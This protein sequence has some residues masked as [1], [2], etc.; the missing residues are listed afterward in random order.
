MIARRI[1]G[2]NG[3]SVV[4]EKHE[5][6]PLLTHES[7]DLRLY[8]WYG[9][10][11]GV[12]VV[13]YL[14]LDRG[15]AHFH[16]PKTPAFIGE[17]TLL[18][19]VLAIAFGTQWLRRA[20]QGD[21]L[22]ATLI[23]YMVWCFF[24]TVPNMHLFGIQVTVRDAA[25]WYYAGFAIALV[26]ACTAVPDLLPKLIRGFR[27]VLPV[28]TVWLPIA[29]LLERSGVQG[30]RFRYSSV[31]LLSHKPGNICCAAVICLAFLL[32]VPQNGNGN[33][34]GNGI[35]KPPRVRLLRQR[36]YR[37]GVWVTL[38]VINV[39]TMLLGATQTRG[40]AVAELLA[41]FVIFLLM[42]R[43][44]RS[45]AIVA[46]V[47]GL[48]LVVGLGL[49]TGASY[50]TQKRTISV[51]QLFENAS[52]LGGG[53][54]AQL[55]GS[56]SF[57]FDLWATILSKQESTSHLLDGFGFGVNL[58]RTGGL[59]PRP[60]QPATLQLRS[61]HN[62]WLDVFART[63]IIGALLYLIVWIGWFRRMGMA[64]RRARDGEIRGVIGVC[65]AGVIALL[66][67]SFFDPTLEGAQVAAVLFTLFAIGIVAARASQSA[68]RDHPYAVVRAALPA[69]P[70]PSA[71]AH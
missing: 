23:A 67:N 31:P 37:S 6:T 26:A 21:I 17:M 51:S 22:L 35:G 9:N 8:R 41:V 60:N 59:N 14:M 29:L 57:R 15:V 20:L 44:R 63:G 61:A 3:T 11:L 64:T 2:A 68:G 40:G 47:A 54:N 55:S 52:S 4:L 10:T 69:S 18:L 66:M 24:R 5:P 39:F 45:Q 65:I 16:L 42:E 34:N 50:H 19:G 36:R 58:A 46:F 49:A 1:N 33:G 28:L 56:V 62:S 71:L 70:A 30:P 12:L 53:T 7:W 48:T 27:V 43:P 25:L 38:I 13:L 32:L